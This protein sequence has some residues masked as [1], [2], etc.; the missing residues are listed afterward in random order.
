MTNLGVLKPLDL[1]G[2]VRCIRVKMQFSQGRKNSILNTG[3]SVHHTLV[4]ELLKIVESKTSPF[5]CTLITSSMGS[6]KTNVF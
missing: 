6:G 5:S 3:L 1:V 2:R 4:I